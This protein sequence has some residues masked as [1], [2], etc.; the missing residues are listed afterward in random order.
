MLW[1][2]IQYVLAI[3]CLLGFVLRFRFFLCFFGE[4]RMSALT[5]Y[6]IA[7]HKNPHVFGATEVLFCRIGLLLRGVVRAPGVEKP[8]DLAKS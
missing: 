7:Q 8:D 5:G 2:E 3:F 4:T 6:S 1:G